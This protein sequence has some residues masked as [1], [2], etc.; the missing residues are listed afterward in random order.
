MQRALKQKKVVACIQARMG[1]GRLPG[2][3]LMDISGKPM[4]WHV[5]ERVKASRIIDTVVVVTTHNKEDVA[6]EALA[7]KCGVYCLKGS[8]KNV[9]DRYYQAAK[10]YNA[11]PVVRITGDCPLIDPSVIDEIITW[12][13]SQKG[14]IH[15]T[16]TP[17]PYPEGQD[18]EVFS[19]YALKEAW[20]YAKKPSEREHVTPYIKSHPEKF[21]SNII[22]KRGEDLSW[23]HW[24]V[25]ESCDIAFVRAVFEHLAGSRR[26]FSMKKVTALLKT[27]SKL[28]KINKGLTG[29]E[30]YQKS[31]K[32][33]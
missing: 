24:S 11:D 7:K 10:R 6:V 22:Q 5:I 4:L 25:D 30:G 21:P 14:N 15:Y 23:M 9:L 27:H 1:S 17:P 26:T 8:E 31:L 13:C 32:E 20:K 12:Y 29:Y 19:F 18:T 28:L 2:K 33:D 16:Y 3:V